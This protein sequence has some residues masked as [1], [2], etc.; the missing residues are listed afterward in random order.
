MARFGK[1]DFDVMNP[2]ERNPNAKKATQQL[3]KMVKKLAKTIGKLVRKF[4]ELLIELG[5][6]GWIILIVLLVII[7][8]VAFFK[9]PGMMQNKLLSVF[10]FNSFMNLTERDAVKKLADD[11]KDIKDVANYLEEMNYSLIGDGFVRPIVNSTVLTKSDISKEHPEY[12]FKFDDNPDEPKEHFYDEDGNIIDGL[13]Y[14]DESGFT[15]DNVTGEK[16]TTGKTYIDEF[17]ITRSTKNLN[18]NGK[19]EIEIKDASDA[20]KYSLIR[21]YL[22]SNYRIY[23][24]K[25]WDE[26]LLSYIGDYLREYFGGNNDG[27]AKGLIKLYIANDDDYYLAKNHWWWGQAIFGEMV[28]ITETSMSLKKGYNN[29]A[30]TY[31]LEGWAPRYG[32]SLEF[33]LSLHL[34]TGAPDLVYA[35]LQNFDT[36]MQ[37]YMRK[38]K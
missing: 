1:K 12:I 10:S 5:P 16:I 25:N 4:V 8:I 36:E 3:G 21:T 20:K 17:G 38:F 34:G 33:L 24:L 19:G 15:V 28:S 35:M 9:M 6:V 26:D 2:E 29:N 11:Y 18:K 31:E 22:L 7:I 13:Q 14:Y 23:T 37:V 32:M 30:M 27:W